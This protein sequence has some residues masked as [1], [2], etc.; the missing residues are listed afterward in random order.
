MTVL[1]SVLIVLFGTLALYTIAVVFRDGV[2][3]FPIY[4]GD[5]FS[6]TWRGQF[7][8]DFA[9]Y[10]ILSALW[11]AW[12]S[13]F[14]TGGVV[15]ALIASILGMVFFAPVVL[16]LIGRSKGDMRRLL[17]GEHAAR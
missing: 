13:G 2:G 9:C 17:L 15:V 16:V 6:V 12:R 7:N 4:F 11:L 10:L 8:L 14:S 3:L 5:L 1:R